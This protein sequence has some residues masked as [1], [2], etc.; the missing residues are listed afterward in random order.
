MG[1][2]SG[3]SLPHGPAC[4][5]QRRA[6]SSS[7]AGPSAASVLSWLTLPQ[8]TRRVL[9]C[10]FANFGAGKSLG[11]PTWWA[12]ID[13]GISTAPPI[14]KT[15]P[16][17]FWFVIMLGLREAIGAHDFFPQVFKL[18]THEFPECTKLGKLYLSETSLL[19]IFAVI[20]VVRGKLPSIYLNY[21]AR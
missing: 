4:L 15:H 1:W 3:G 12:H 6:A 9:P 13:H 11:A 21:L 10:K 14:Q 8:L 2:H 17:L 7:H 19:S 16:H 5:F 18:H 20:F